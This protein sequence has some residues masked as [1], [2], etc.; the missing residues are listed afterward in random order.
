MKLSNLFF[1]KP[2][3]VVLRLRAHPA[4]PP[5]FKTIGTVKIAVKGGTQ[6]DA[7]LIGPSGGKP[8]HVFQMAQLIEIHEETEGLELRHVLSGGVERRRPVKDIFGEE[9]QL[10]AAAGPEVVQSP[11]AFRH[12]HQMVKSGIL[13]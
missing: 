8:R 13:Q 6:T 5:V 11:P 1:K 7:D 4:R 3:V 2:H 9:A 10:Q 12:R